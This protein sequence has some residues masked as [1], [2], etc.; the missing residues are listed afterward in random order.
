MQALRIRIGRF[1]G[2]VALATAW[3]GGCG[4]PQATP[5]AAPR[6]TGVELRI[7]A[8]GNPAILEAIR[9]QSGEWEEQTGARLV[10]HPEAVSPAE[11]GEYD[12]LVYA[13]D[14]MGALVDA[15]SLA[16]IPE[17][18]VRAVGLLPIGSETAADESSD[19]ELGAPRRDP[20]DFTDVA[21]PLREQA[22][23][24]GEDRMGLPIGST[25]PVL[26]YRRDAFSSEA[27]RQAAKQA[28]LTLEP[29]KS[30][31]QLDALARFF[32][33]RDWNGD[34]EA[35]HGLAVALGADAEGVG[36]ATYLSRAAALGQAPDQFALL[37]DADGP[38]LTPWIASEPFVEAL[39]GMA[40]WRDC[41]PPEMTSFDAGAAREAFRDGRTAMLI[42]LAERASSWTDPKRPAT[43]GL[44][45][46]PGSDRV[47]D[48]LRKE[49]STPVQTNRVAYLPTG[50]GWFAG[51]GST[52]EGRT[53]EAAIAFLQAIASPETAVAIISDPAFPM[54]PVRNSHFVLGLPD[55]QSALG[56]D[57]RAWGQAVA[58]TLGAPRVVIGL[59]I[60]EARGYLDDLE[61]ARTKAAQGEDPATLLK[62]TADAWTQRTRRLGPAQQRWH[63]RRSLNRLSTESQPPRREAE[64]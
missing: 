23:K 50:G 52:S 14:R 34:G 9:V 26:I 10:I 49:W 15:G 16:L 44:A 55:P 41:G 11:A 40:A 20:L 62:R 6:F 28:S 35:D 63:Y 27:N 8:V 58:E 17:Q 51:L 59:R 56:V 46:L 2:I 29:P 33:G 4:D 13:G 64:R 43:V 7:A 25:G 32:Q 18:A 12:V 37:F 61:I 5:S 42:D 19:E 31:D 21:L 3:I 48:P 30:W 54:L 24:Y 57:P 22:G 53:R 36:M 38:D 1:S 39:R 60:P 45:A 47:Y